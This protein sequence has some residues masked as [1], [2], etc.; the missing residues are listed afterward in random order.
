MYENVTTYVS[1]ITVIFGIFGIFLFVKLLSSLKKV[2]VET[3]KA[4]VFLAKDFVIKNVVIIFIVG[5]LIAIHNFIE[6]LG[7]G[8]P[9]FYYGT[10]AANYPTRLFAVTELFVAILLV[11][12]LMYKWIKI[13]KI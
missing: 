12:W 7:L 10:I 2:N 1:G 8:H 13:I 5:I 9:E 6:Y 11:D 3:L 4:R